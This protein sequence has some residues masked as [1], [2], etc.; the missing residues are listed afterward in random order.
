M[1]KRAFSARRGQKP[2]RPVFNGQTSHVNKLSALALAAAFL[3]APFPPALARQI[4]ADGR[5]VT[6]GLTRTAGAVLT[7]LGSLLGFAQGHRQGEGMPPVDRNVLPRQSPRKPPTKAER[8]ERV[9]A[10][11]ISPSDE[12]MIQSR[13]PL[14]LVAVPVDAAGNAVQG[15]TASWESSDR[16]VVFVRPDGQA[17]GGKP[18]RAK[19]TA[20][21]G[22]KKASVH[23][24][25][26]EVT[27]ER[28]GGRKKDTVRQR[29][30]AARRGGD[31]ARVIKAAWSPDDM[32]S[33]SSRGEAPS[34][35][36]GLIRPRGVALFLRPPEEDPLPDNETGSMYSPSNSVGSPPGRTTPGAVTPPVATGGTEMPGSSNFSFEVP[37][38]S[39]PGR[40]LNLSLALAYNSRLWNKST[41]AWG[42]THVTY[43]VDSG[44]PAPGFRLGFGQIESQGSQG[45]TLTDA[46][47][48]RHQLVKTNPSNQYDYNY[49]SIDGTFIR[50]YGGQGWGTVTYPDG[51]R[52]E[53]GAAGGGFRSYPTRII[54]RN[55]NYMLVSYV[56]GVGPRISTVQ[57]TLGRYVRFYYDA[58]NNLV[59]VTAPG[60]EG[61]PDRQT[62]RFYYEDMAVS[63]SFQVYANAPATARVIRYVYAPGA[64]N[65]FRY[66][67]S[68]YGMIYRTTQLRGMSA[69]YLGL[70]QTGWIS[71]EGQ[72]AAWSEYN[73]PTGPANLAD[74]PTF[75]RRTD[76]WAGRTSGMP[77]TGAAP[78]HTFSAD[79]AQGISTA[80]APDQT[81]TETHTIVSPGAWND[82]LVSETIIRQG[83]T[84]LGRV[85]TDWEADAVGRN[86]RPQTVRT[87]NEAGQTKAI[88]LTYTSYNN[89]AVYSER[90]S[91]A[92]GSVGP[93][94]RRTETTYETRPEWTS[95]GLVRLP[96][97]VRVYAGG[98]AAPASRVDYAYDTA[99]TNLTPRAD[100]IMHDDAYDPFAPTVENCYWE[101]IDDG[102][103]GCYWNYHCDYYNPYDPSTDKRGNVTSITKY[104]DAA[105]GTGA[106]TYA[107]AYDVTGNLVSETA[108]C[109]Q[110]KS[111]SY[112]NAYWYAYLTS[113]SRGNAGQLTTGST[114]DFNTGLRR[115]VTNEN[116]QT[117]TM[118][119]FP[120]SLR[121]M[122]TNFPDGSYSYNR[123]HDT[124]IADPDGAHLH[125][126]IF[127]GIYVA[128]GKEVNTYE[129]FDGRGAQARV[130][131]STPDGYETVD[132]ESDFMGRAYR[133]SN[134]YFS[135]GSSS[136]VNPTGQWT[137]TSYDALS[138]AV[139]ITTPDGNVSRIDYAG[140]VTTVTDQA[141]K[142][143]RSVADAL[144]RV[145]RVDEPDAAGNLGPADQPTQ[146]T[147]Y[148]YNVFDKVV[149]IAQGAQHR[150]FKYD[151][152]GRLTHERQVEQDAPHYD[153]DPLTGN[154]YWSRRSAYNGQGLMTD[155]WDARGVQTHVEYD[156]VNRVRQVSYS[157]GTPTVTY[158]YD[159]ARPGYYNHAQL[160]EVV[161]TLPD[162][163]QQTALAYDYDRMGRVVAHRQTVGPR[164]YQIGYAYN[165]LGQVTSLTYPSG[166][167]V[168]NSYDWTGRL[169]G[170]AD[171]TRTYAS[172]FAYGPNG[173]MISET[174]G[175]GAVHTLGYNSRQQLSQIRLVVGGVERQ[176][177]DYAY[178]EV[179]A[180][181]GAV[182]AAKN[183]GQIARVES[184]VD[185]AKQWQQRYNY[186]KLGRLTLAGEFRGDDGALVYRNHYEYD[187]YGNRY[188]NGGLNQNVTYTPVAP[189]DINQA[190]NR[191]TNGVSYDAAGNI[192]GDWKFRGMQYSYDANGRQRTAWRN[193]GT[194]GTSAVYDGAGR[195][196]QSSVNGTWR[197][198]VYD[199][200]GRLIAEYTLG[201]LE[202]ENIYRGSQLLA[203][204]EAPR[205][206][207]LTVEQFVR[208]FFQGALARQPNASELQTWVDRLSRAQAQ[209]YA[210][211]LGEA[212]RLGNALFTSPEYA[213]RNRP[214][215][216][217][218]YDLYWGYLQREPD[219]GGWDFW[220]SQVAVNG[221]DNVRRGFDQ[222]IEFQNKVASICPTTG[223]GG[224]LRYL[225]MDHQSSI[226]VVMDSAG[227]ILARHDYQP[228]GEEVWAATGQRTTAQGFGVTDRVR[229]RY[230]GIERD[231][232]TG[233]DH[234][235]W[236]KYDGLQG[237]WTTPDP[238]KGS[239]NG[240][241]PQSFNRYTYVDNDPINRVDPTGLL[242]CF[243]Y[244]V[245]LLRVDAE[246]GRV[247]SSEYLGFLP[248]SC[249]DDSP[250]GFDQGG[251]G[252][253]GGQGGRNVGPNG[254]A[255]QPPRSGPCNLKTASFEE[256]AKVNPAAAQILNQ[257]FGKDAKSKYDS[258]STYDQAVFLNT[259]AAVGDA[260]VDLSNA[261]FKDF[262]FDKSK[263]PFGV[264]V[265]GV[266]E[267]QLDKAE[268]GNAIFHGRRSPGRIKE[269]SLEASVHKDKSV[270]FDIDLWN[271][272]SEFRKHQ[273]EVGWNKDNKATTHPAD[274]ARALN[275]RGVQSGVT[276]K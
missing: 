107:Y 51:A 261:R 101:C 153:Y 134:P 229:Y 215:R 194:G 110:Q 122:Q 5:S 106:T 193:D 43:D 161:T 44:W 199:V 105:G 217:Y 140:T 196:V 124:F 148:D 182:D 216:D 47:G 144:G 187:R 225:L 70:D 208:N 255:N 169:T 3:T 272:K 17:V 273:E 197:D 178:G 15:L 171:G 257:T 206:C 265:T 190:N 23:V 12:V 133:Q 249:W 20:T 14:V 210:P 137:V 10:V 85:K 254:A 33:G 209:G 8:E 21:A 226:R 128:P 49:E 89:V 121:H 145:R 50:F 185:G 268:L 64:G 253:G 183:N 250:R 99:G 125:S 11:Q 212:Q 174:W 189:A 39:L 258:W 181:T 75:T 76:D 78:Y 269:A 221:R 131:N 92:D 177:F 264:T 72:A 87:T 267:K 45:F 97:S 163:S 164:V 247:I 240:G 104:A 26:V 9:A 239:M 130:F 219:Q 112:S 248:V 18:G 32:P 237:R 40:G 114:Y 61:G 213:A 170:V 150:Y 252:G 56:G 90:D 19:L 165:G 74:A 109:C 88:V 1:L 80:T 96:T 149:H 246:T 142:A 69:N 86:A 233:L 63:T 82:G 84:V 42:N 241:D 53:Y 117:S 173:L 244:H 198:M 65:G 235:W 91:T 41:D 58:G 60:Y 94:L 129:F 158:R 175:N 236:R 93:E 25:V 38:V 13:E 223:A 79:E 37:V 136:P 220:T 146:P 73:Y 204:D 242:T 46:D 262:Y 230:G 251:G 30:G 28:F 152:L 135:G 243:G 24:T 172:N 36:A 120:D 231:D 271:S 211:L 201:Q 111:Y 68:A 95:R 184:F 218:V 167:V 62:I 224:G 245:F 162:G 274:A 192:T 34:A 259:M 141:G 179:N 266:T 143:K 176:R 263:D 35:A 59:A 119:Y 214:D 275:R 222:S 118:F 22:Q 4:G 102:W 52:V 16:Q 200:N 81:A 57:D 138:R 83:A 180:D 238:Y 203:T 66:D 67:Y 154:H 270:S 98:S 77:G 126:Y 159:Q 186:D 31:G 139:A 207:S 55:G 160:T 116:G 123:Y 54:D 157:D 2:G 113:E 195:R 27:R 232:A 132:I 256:L 234:T 205:A 155:T 127:T 228:F 156:G 191:F 202:R 29:V 48:T 260:G 276:C 168:T 147:F 227:N 6:A 108:D 115:T 7:S 166:R 71:S 100:V 188:Q 103:G 151:S